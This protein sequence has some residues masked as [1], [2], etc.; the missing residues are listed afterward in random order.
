[1]G[2]FREAGRRSIEDFL[3][4]E[5]LGLTAIGDWYMLLQ[6]GENVDG[7]YFNLFVDELVKLYKTEW[8]LEYG[9]DVEATGNASTTLE[10]G[11]Q[12]IPMMEVNSSQQNNV[13]A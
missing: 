5:I 6:V 4:K 1:M 3:E 8:R 11:N 9:E 13:S 2:R 10:Q 12:E 7:H